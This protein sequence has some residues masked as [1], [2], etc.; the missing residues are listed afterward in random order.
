MRPSE[1]VSESVFFLFFFPDSGRGLR[2]QQQGPHQVLVRRRSS[3]DGGDQLGWGWVGGWWLK[4]GSV[5][6]SG[7]V[8]VCVRVCVHLPD[9]GWGHKLHRC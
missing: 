1:L 2:L 9:A 3:P 7:R 8:G 6:L 4:R 5:D